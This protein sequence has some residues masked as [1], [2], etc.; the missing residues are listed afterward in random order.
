MQIRT[1][2]GILVSLAL[3]ACLGVLVNQNQPLLDQPFK[4]A[5]GRM[6]P[7][8]TVLVASFLTGVLTFLLLFLLRG[9]ADLVERWRLLQGRKAGRAVDELYTRG[10][11]AVMEGREEKAL[12]HFQSILSREPEHFQA[13]IK[14]GSVLRSLKRLPEAVE[15]HKRAHRLR[16]T[17]MEPLYELVKDYEALDQVAKAKVVLNRIIQL[18]PRRALSAYRNLRKYAIRENDW[19]RA[20][21]VQALIEDQIEK[22]PYKLEAERRYSIGIRY[23]M[24]CAAAHQGKDK[25]ALNALRRLTRSDPA[26]VPAHLKL[27]EIL[28]RQGQVE[29]AVQVWAAGFEQTGS[30]VFLNAIEEHFLAEED[31]ESAIEAIQAAVARSRKD[32]LPRFFLAKL[33]MRLEMIDAALREFSALSSRATTSPTLHA[34][35]GAALE[36]R[37]EYRE[38]AAE[39]RQVIKDL[40]Y[41]KLQYRCQVCDERYAAWADRC[42]ICGEWNQIALDF[43]ED[44]SL[45]DLGL[46]PGPVYSSTA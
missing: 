16:D 19:E 28:K 34:Y 13:L 22:T 6:V 42:A 45:E 36:R 4:I 38:S 30:P 40:E 20:W 46:S 7:L 15:M 39:Y 24:A 3:V 23:E 33:Y 29:P 1:F 25:D 5:T 27:G 17:D 14:A 21:E 44:P 9:S 35:L 31:P 2:L 8:W 12:E 32:F 26:F 41:L 11:E 18:R 43:G 10:V 37:G